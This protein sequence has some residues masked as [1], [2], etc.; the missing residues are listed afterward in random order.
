MA[1]IT[2]PAEER[3]LTDPQEI[4][5]FLSPHGIWFEKWD[6]D[7][8]LS[9][10]VTNEEILTAYEA[11]ISRLKEQGGYQTADVIAVSAETP[12][13]DE[14][15]AKFAKEHTH[16]EDEV[17]FTIAGRGIFHIH[18]EQGPVFGITVESGDLINVPAG[19]KHWFNL[20]E[21]KTI[22]CIWLFCCLDQPPLADCH[23]PR[24]GEGG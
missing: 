13:V 21:D 8:R 16:S 2:I 15:C 5:D 7:G 6:V 14:M 3:R 17:R 22:R 20:C 1:V 19:T 9:G 23:L 11:E 4:R 24:C 12:G 18:P 10:E